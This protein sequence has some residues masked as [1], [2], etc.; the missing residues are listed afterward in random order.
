LIAIDVS[1][2]KIKFY[3]IDIKVI[4]SLLRYGE[5]FSFFYYCNHL[6]W[7]VRESRDSSWSLLFVVACFLNNLQ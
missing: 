7:L 5:R 1:I 4:Y 3:I 2:D 6:C